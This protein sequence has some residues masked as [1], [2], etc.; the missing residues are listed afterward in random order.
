MRHYTKESV[1]FHSEHY[2]PAHPAVNV[3]VHKFVS[4]SKIAEHF[5]CSE[6][7]AEKALEFCFESACQQFWEDAPEHAESIFGKHVEV[8]SEGRS[9][10]WLIVEGLKSFDEWNAIDLA[11]WRKFE[12]ECKAAVKDLT[13]FAWCIDIIDANNWCQ[14]GAERYNFIDTKDGK[15]VC[16]SELKQKAVDAGFEPVIRQ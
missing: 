16:I 7:L 1:E 15:T 10:G 3:K 11:K 9:G 2:R 6:E 4:S 5:K 12:N 8:H 13:S 14:V